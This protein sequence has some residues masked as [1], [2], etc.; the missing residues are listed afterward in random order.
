VSDTLLHGGV[1]S[2][3]HVS[4]IMLKVPKREKFVTELFTL[5][6]P[7]WKGDMRTE[8]KNHLCKVLS[9]IRHFVSLAM[10]E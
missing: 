9:D 3:R 1:D 6:D 5:S 7:I 2:S 8:P 4:C 10:T